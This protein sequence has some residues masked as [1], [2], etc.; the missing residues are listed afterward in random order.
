VWP[1]V[2]LALEAARPGG[3]LHRDPAAGVGL[4]LNRVQPVLGVATLQVLQVLVIDQSHFL[5]CHRG[6]RLIIVVTIHTHDGSLPEVVAPYL[7]QATFPKIG[8]RETLN[9]STCLHSDVL[10]S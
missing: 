1:Q 3:P 6:D 4:D 5:D 9:V 7:P 2:D 8:N 10:D